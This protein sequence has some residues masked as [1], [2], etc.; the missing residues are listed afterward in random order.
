MK[1]IVCSLCSLAVIQIT[2][3]GLNQ[4]EEIELNRGHETWIAP[5]AEERNTGRYPMKY[6]GTRRPLLSTFSSRPWHMSGMNHFHLD[7]RSVF[8]LPMDRW[9]L[10]PRWDVIRIFN[11]AVCMT[12]S[13]Q[14]KARL[15]E[16][17][18]TQVPGEIPVKKA[19]RGT[20]LFMAKRSTVRK[21]NGYE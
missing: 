6:S 7:S 4:H 18:C 5:G 17:L 1:S 16:P 15:K 21:L 8:S 20:R 10:M 2:Q 3:R 14:P 12:S 13:T 9:R 19:E 11:P